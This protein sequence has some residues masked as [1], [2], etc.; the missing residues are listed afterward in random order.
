MASGVSDDRY[1][2]EMESYAEVQA[3]IE[4]YLYDG[5][6]EPPSVS[7]LSI[8][9]LK[10]KAQEAADDKVWHV[11]RHYLLELFARGFEPSQTACNLARLSSEQDRN[12]EAV[13]WYRREL[14]IEPKNREDHEGLIFLLDCHPETTAQEALRE[15]MRYFEKFGAPAYALRQP[16]R[17]TPEPDRPIKI[18]YVTGDWNF[19]S[20]SVAFVTAVSEHSDG[21]VAYAYST[22]H[23]DNSDNVTKE[24]KR[25]LGSRYLECYG[26]S[27]SQLA[28]VIRH[29]EIDILVDLAGYTA[30]NRLQTFAYRPAPIQVQAWGYVLG[31][32]SPAIDVIFADPIVAPPS[33][34]ASLV[35]RVYHLPSLLGFKPYD[36]MEGQTALPCL[37]KPPVFGVF[38][39]GIKV[40]YQTLRVWRRVLEA[41]PG[42]RLMFKSADYNPARRLEILDAL[43][44]F[45][46]RIDFAPPT[47]YAEH[48]NYYQVVDLSLDTWPQTG[49]VSTLESI[50]MGVP[51]VTLIGERMIQRTSASILTNVGFPECIA[52]TEDEYVATAVR[53][54]T[55]DKDRLVEMR[56]TARERLL[57]SPICTGYAQAV[58]QAYRALWREWCAMASDTSQMVN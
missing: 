53:L 33:V 28:A 13:E 19:H 17:N 45:Q 6:P 2:N 52:Q 41:V 26:L 43:T 51:V 12:G 20:A 35:E 23:P 11:C 24:W 54:V 47:F 32:G 37:T 36:T 14:E 1:V 18:G 55:T 22:L 27:P 29:D 56:A 3:F 38:Q 21:Y 7:D 34:Q 8:D 49:G 46:D 30:K 4:R 10:Q 44:G 39:R 9:D 42:S 50:Y 58:E 25:H 5:P 40:N 31:S 57:A 16:H 48:L 15:R